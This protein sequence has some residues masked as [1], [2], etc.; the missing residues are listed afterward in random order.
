MNDKPNP[1]RDERQERLADPLAGTEFANLPETFAMRTDDS[2]IIQEREPCYICRAECF[3]GSGMQGT[4]YLEGSIVVTHAVPNIQMEPL[5]RAAALKFVAWQSRLPNHRYALD[6]GDMSEAAHIL[7]KNPDVL[8]L[9]SVQWQEAVTALAIK[10]KQKREGT[11]SRELPAIGHNF[12]QMSPNKQAP[13]ILGAKMSVQS[14]RLPG[15]AQSQRL[16]G[17]TRLA[18]AIPSH[19]A[20]PIVRR[21]A[22]SPMGTPP[23]R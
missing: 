19:E 11:E 10:L 8:K 7:A 12:T 21:A 22:N 17:E 2:A 3:L 5:N 20:G 13:P 23:G 14:Q 1:P 15:E 6:V 4:Q 16:P 9:D 18:T